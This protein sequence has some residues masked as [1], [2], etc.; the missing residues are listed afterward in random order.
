MKKIISLLL[1]ILMLSGVLAMPVSAL[2]Y[3]VSYYE[4]AI[5]AGGVVDLYAYPSVG[6]PEDYTYQWQYD[7]GFGDGHWYDIEENSN[8]SGT[9]TNHL[10]MYTSIGN[11]DS[12]EKIPFQCV[13][14]ASDGT[15]RHTDNI[16]MYIYPTDKLIPNMKNWGYGLY[17]P[18]IT[19]AADLYTKD[20]VN[21]TASTCAGTNLK[22]FCGSKPV[23]D[24]PILRKS[25]VAL[26]TEIHITENGK[27]TVS[28]NSTSY[29]PYMVGKTQVQIKEKLTIGGADLGYFDTKTIDITV[30]KPQVISTGTAKSDCSL[31]RYTYNESQKLA[32][33]SKGTSLEIV[34]EEGS[35][36]QVYYNGYVGYVGK[37]LLSS[38]AIAAGKL[39]TNV[40]VTIAKPVAGQTP[41]GTCTIATSGCELYKTDPITW[42]DASGKLLKATDKFQ[43]GQKYTVSIWVAAKSG[44][45]FQTDAY[46]KPKLT[47]A[48]NGDL[49]PFINKAYEQDPKE[50]IELTY[51]FAGAQKAPEATEPPKTTTPT[52]PAHTHTVSDWRTT[53]AYHYTVCTSCGE[54]L[55]QEDHKGGTATCSAKGKCSVCG[56]EYI[57]ENENH[58]PDTSKWIPRGEMYHFHACKFCGAHCDT[59]DHRWSPTYLYQDTTGH[60]WICADCKA[61]SQVEKHNPGPAATE[62]TPQTCKDCDYIIE[63]AKNHT[64]KLTKVPMVEP[65]CAQEGRIAYYSCDGCSK[66]FEDKDGKKEIPD[67]RDLRLPAIAHSSGEIWEYDE[68]FHW[69]SCSACSE[70]LIETQMY[71]EMENGVCLTCG[72]K[73]GVKP[74]AATEAATE[75]TTHVKTEESITP[76]TSDPQEALPSQ[77]KPKATIGPLAAVLIGVVCF[78]AAITTTV[79]IL[80]K[81]GKKI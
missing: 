13:V 15:V 5:Y 46:G 66:L 19:N 67:T 81:R 27:T 77:E 36:Y 35:Y 22:I 32:S 58:T 72:Y 12:W 49:P 11:Y 6:D 78:F 30:A 17:T 39:I 26:T 62:T 75:A 52:E 31:L 45:E 55:E 38:N 48:I 79:M 68:T 42:T 1:C 8:Y 51:T 20:D 64:H 63:P 23:D 10:R 24:K 60:A 7:A 29:I 3:Y 74:S 71:H 2:S 80:K 54:F 44:Y 47:G 61:H 43:E 65:T 4:E 18:S 41:A 25:E 69:R 33:I 16:Y 37:T 53:G 50:V 28:G 73:A 57:E 59:E 56:Y 76:A 21:Y 14:T 9:K 70:I 34:G 40:D